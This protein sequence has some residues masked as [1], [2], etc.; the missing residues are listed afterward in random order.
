MMGALQQMPAQTGLAAILAALAPATQTG[1][2]EGGF[3][4]LIDSVPLSGANALAAPAAPAAP[5]PDASSPLA[6]ANPL[7][8]ALLLAADSAAWSPDGLPVAAPDAPVPASPMPVADAGHDSAAMAARLLISV[9]APATQTVPAADPVTSAPPADASGETAEDIDGTAQDAPAPVAAPTPVE[10]AEVA[11]VAA[12][13]LTAPTQSPANREKPAAERPA[14]AAAAISAP[15]R[16]DGDALPAATHT[17]PASPRANE[18]LQTLAG[19]APRAEPH[20][21]RSGADAGAAMT[22]IFAQP[23]ATGAPLAAS[24]AQPVPMAERTLDMTSDDRWIGQL[25]ADIAATKSENGDLSFRLMPRHLGRLDIAMKMDGDGAVSLKLDTQ[26]EA[27]ATI[28]AAAQPRLVED[29]R[30]QGV[31]VAEAQVTHTPAETG[32]QPQQQQGHGAR[33]GTPDASHL[34]ETAADR[35]ETPG[36]DS[37]ADRRGRFA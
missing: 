8:P 16:A 25:A 22:V 5:Q 28:V 4:Q 18:V 13:P 26:H 37:A 35:P 12:A 32:R 14:R 7:P 9:S 30:H 3:E 23:A 24:P 17:V 15:R 27:T 10:T 19:F 21:P 2:G 29:L 6:G 11:A 36:N 20:A 1:G 31:R 34:I 33:H